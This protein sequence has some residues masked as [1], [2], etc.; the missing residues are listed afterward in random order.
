MPALESHCWRGFVSMDDTLLD[1]SG[2]FWR[3]IAYLVGRKGLEQAYGCD[4]EVNSLVAGGVVG[5]AAGL[6]GGIAGTVGT[7]LVLPEG[8]SAL[9]IGLPVGVHVGDEIG[10]AG[11]LEEGGDVGVGTRAVAVLVIAAV[12]V[13]GPETVDGP[14]IIRAGDRVGIPELDLLD[15]AVRTADAAGVRRRA[16]AREHGGVV[17]AGLVGAGEGN[18]ERN[19]QGSANGL[20]GRHS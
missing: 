14:R 19:C 9:I 3:S 12:A 4:E 13:V 6:E 8:L 7:P 15:E 1:I 2:G 10:L 18:G 17:G 16:A 5:V 11:V 20:E